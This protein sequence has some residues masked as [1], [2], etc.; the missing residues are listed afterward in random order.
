M[1]LPVKFL[2]LYVGS[3]VRSNGNLHV[4]L[5][6]PYGN[7]VASAPGVSGDHAR[8]LHDRVVNFLIKLFKTVG[9]PVKEWVRR[10][11][12][13]TFGKCFHAGAEVSEEDMRAL[14]GI[15]PDMAIDARDS[16]DGPFSSHND[17]VGRKISC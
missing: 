6:D 7:G 1:G 13:S 14:Q 2:S 16:E 15:I 11:C 10:P 4:T 3:R 9:V 12:T 8:R 5:V 17:F